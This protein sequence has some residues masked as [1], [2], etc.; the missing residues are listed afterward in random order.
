MGIKLVIVDDAPFIREA[1]RIIAQKAG[2]DFVG[3]ATNGQEAVDVCSQKNP[4]VVIMDLVMPKMNGIDATKEI[5]KKNSKIKIIACST[6]SQDAM[7][8]E[9]VQAGCVGFITKPFDAA[10]VQKAIEDAKKR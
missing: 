9:A 3:E 8:I 5:L 7:L 10:K 2:F 1:L 4:D 6:E